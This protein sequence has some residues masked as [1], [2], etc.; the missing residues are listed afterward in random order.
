MKVT[1]ITDILQ[2]FDAITARLEEKFDED[3]D[4][5]H[6]V[7]LFKEKTNPGN[8]WTVPFVTGQA[9]N[10]HWRYGMTFEQMEFWRQNDQW[11][12]MQKGLM[13]QFNR[14]GL[15]LEAVE[16]VFL[17][18]EDENPETLNASEM[19]TGPDVIADFPISSR[20]DWAAELSA[21]KSSQNILNGQTFND[22]ENEVTQL[23]IAPGPA[24]G[25]SQKIRV[26]QLRCASFA[27]CNPGLFGGD[28]EAIWRTWD[29]EGE[30]G[31]VQA[32]EPNENYPEDQTDITT[33]KIILPSWQMEYNVDSA[34]VES[35]SIEGVLKIKP[36]ADRSLTANRI[37][38]GRYGELRVGSVDEPF[39]DNFNLIV[40][41][42]M[43][44]THLT[45]NPDVDI[46][47]KG[48]ANFGL[49]S[50][51]GA[52]RS[53]HKAKLLESLAAEG[54]VIKV[55]ATISSDW[56]AGDRLGVG[57][58]G[59]DFSEYEEFEI[60]SAGSNPGE[61]NVKRVDYSI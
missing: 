37:L 46:G 16:S 6:S 1:R 19:P 34:T 22:Y 24:D 26:N 60:I 40:T 41:G 7:V 47:N 8:A 25:S 61:F 56:A 58:T 4:R 54:E 28:R 23:W 43:D 52:P 15:F 36:G 11:D 55:D 17:D 12:Y 35:L 49:L 14:T 10:I 57:P 48:I 42:N 38:I 18:G 20:P 39:T 21:T 13:L 31:W 32:G 30:Q 51:H 9:Y 44:S 2:D 29:G 59:F 3:A 33:D 27:T 53:G 45:G 50:V 5:Y